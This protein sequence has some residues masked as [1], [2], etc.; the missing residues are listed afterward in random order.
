MIQKDYLEQKYIKKLFSVS[1][2]AKELN[3]SESKVTYWIQK[4]GLKKRT[5]SEAQYVKRNPEGD[6]FIFKSPQ[7]EG[8]WFLYGLALGLYWGEGN[9]K[10]KTAVRIGNTDPDLLRY[11]L[12]FLIQM[13]RVDV[14]RLRYGLQIFTD[15]DP[16]KAKMFWCVKLN[17]S[18]MSFQK[19]IVTP[20]VKRGTYTQ[21]SEYGVLTIHFSN[22][23]IRDTIVDAIE[24]LRRQTYANVAQSVERVHG[25]SP[26]PARSLRK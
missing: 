16:E 7:T 21:K 10:S 22:T 6:P 23:K 2:I 1:V 11:F 19:I 24:A 4:H 8:E 14:S 17:V 9:K 12:D 18:P 13:Y 3:C 26:D 25:G 20:S 5:I 15:I